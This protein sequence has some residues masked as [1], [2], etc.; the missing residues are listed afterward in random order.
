VSDKWT[1]PG[2][3]KCHFCPEPDSGYALK[4]EQGEWQP[5]CW[6]CVKRITGWKPEAPAKKNLIKKGESTNV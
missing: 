3:V 6:T 4:D 5:A 2:E 1:E